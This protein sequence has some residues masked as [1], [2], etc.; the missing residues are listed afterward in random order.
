MERVLPTA[1]VCETA[2]SLDLARKE[3]AVEI[4][5]GRGARE[6]AGANGSSCIV[7]EWTRFPF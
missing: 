2:E 4:G 3:A 1:F 7:L 5:E 6:G